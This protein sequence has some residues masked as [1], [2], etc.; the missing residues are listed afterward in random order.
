MACL[1]LSLLVTG[2][3]LSPALTGVLTALTGGW[4]LP[5]CDEV[6]AA[7]VDSSLANNCTKARAATSAWGDRPCHT[8][9]LFLL[10]LISYQDVVAEEHNKHEETGYNK[11]V[12]N[13]SWTNLLT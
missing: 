3:E 4:F 7:G 6:E 12:S 8:A 5:M 10:M 1:T 9:T 11:K 13:H 2:W